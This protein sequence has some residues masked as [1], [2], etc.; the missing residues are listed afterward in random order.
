MWVFFR[1]H[2][3]FYQQPKHKAKVKV[4]PLLCSFPPGST[5]PAP[6]GGGATFGSFLL[7]C[8]CASS[9]PVTT[10]SGSCAFQDSSCCRCISGDAQTTLCPPHAHR[11]MDNVWLFGKPHLTSPLLPENKVLGA[12]MAGKYGGDIKQLLPRL[13]EAEQG[14][15]HEHSISASSPSPWDLPKMLSSF[16]RDVTGNGIICSE[17]FSG[18]IL[19]F[20]GPCLYSGKGTPH[21]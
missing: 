11:E 1:A 21:L 14:C 13:G 18:C 3:S 9:L 5:L 20:H 8:G 2:L 17:T 19:P 6:Q 12:E 7:W 10:A 16:P 4:Q 15:P